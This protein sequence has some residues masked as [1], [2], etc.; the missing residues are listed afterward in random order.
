MSDP[1]LPKLD[2]TG[3]LGKFPVWVWGLIAVGVA[4][5]AYYLLRGRSGAAVSGVTG[6]A[7]MDGNGYQTEGITGGSADTSTIADPTETNMQWLNRVS[8]AVADS[9]G[10][11]PSAVF[12]ALFKYITGQDISVTEKAYVDAAL[13]IGGNPPEGV[14]GVS[15]VVGVKTPPTPTNPTPKPPTTPLKKLLGYVKSFNSPDIYATYSD[16]SR[17][18]LSFAAWTKLGKPKPQT[19][20]PSLS[21]VKQYEKR[22]G[23]PDIYAVGQDGT[24]TKLTYDQYK[25]LGSPKYVIV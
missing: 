16:G 2:F 10:K 1:Q 15:T 23:N 22:A 8:K 24:R 7:S 20:T 12:A 4:L 21:K 11:S 18:K 3:K 17:T 14:Q 6:S 5:I 9:S 19:A 13:N 25:A